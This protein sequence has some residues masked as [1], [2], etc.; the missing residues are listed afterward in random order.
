MLGAV[1][2]P[3][4]RPRQITARTAIVHDWFQGFHGAERVVEAMRTGLLAG[5]PDIYTFHAARDLLPPDLAAAIVR[6]SRLAGLPGIRQR[7]HTPGLW[8]NLLPFMPRYF[9]R[10]DLDAYD[11]VISSSHAFSANVRVR[12]DALH[13]CYCYTPLRYAWLPELERGRVRGPRAVALGLLR[14]R[15]RR[16]DRSA[17][18]RPDGYVA[19]STS[20]RERIRSF[21]GRD[22]A[23]V[24]PPVDVEEFD[25]TQERDAETFLWVHRLVSYKHPEVVVDAFRDL[26]CRLTMVGVGPLERRLRRNLPPNVELRSWVSRETLT[27]LFERSAGFIHVA[28]EDFGITMVE[29]LAAGTPVIAL[30]RGG[31]CDIVRSGV[32]GLLLDRLDSGAVRTAVR[33]LQASEWDRSVL[34]DGAKRFSRSQFVANLRSYLDELG[35]RK[36]LEL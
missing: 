30:R 13:V 35:E 9:A 24:H 25:P 11:L 3:D 21:Y 27:R 6:E 19:I 16:I 18:A 1:D 17:S 5:A 12:S 15:L 10:L 28:D 26:P 33:T 8:R 31:A 22:A 20:V 4:A 29:A 36:S 14:N 2:E 23:I 7:G 32:D 34:A